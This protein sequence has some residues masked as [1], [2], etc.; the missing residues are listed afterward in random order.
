MPRPTSFQLSAFKPNQRGSSRRWRLACSL[1]FPLP[2]LS[3]SLSSTKPRRDLF[4]F[5]ASLTLSVAKARLF[6]LFTVFI[7]VRSREPNSFM[8][9]P[10]RVRDPVAVVAC[11]FGPAG[12]VSELIYYDP[13]I[14]ALPAT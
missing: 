1:L 12:F 14:S 13:I 3:L 11:C 7:T 9:T 4:S 5:Q 6:G 2:S 10:F 8:P